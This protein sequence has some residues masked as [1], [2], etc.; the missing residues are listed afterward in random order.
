MK[1]KYVVALSLIAL[2]VI[3]RILPH[4]ANFAPMSAVAIFAGTILPRK[5]ALFVSLLAIV[6]SDAIIG[7]YDTMPATWACFAL[8]TLASSFWLK[9]PNLIKGFA[10]TIT[11]SV[12]FFVVTNFAV[13]AADDMYAH[14]WNGLAQCFV[15]ALPFFRNTAASDSF[16]TAILFGVFAL[17]THAQTR[18][19][20]A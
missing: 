17:A 3:L 12:F 9:K 20:V 10:V 11:S 19:Q 8:V 18:K 1:A 5:I 14:T 4:P 15:M 7:F 6:I 16:Y 13:W 2:A